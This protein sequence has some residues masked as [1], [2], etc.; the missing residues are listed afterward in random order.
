MHRGYVKIWRKSIDGGWL[1]NPKLWTFWCYCLLRA[2]H[3]PCKV[4]LGFTEIELEPGQFIFGRKQASKDIGLS[5]RTVRTC[6][7]T[8]KTTS[9]V[10]IK[11]TNRYSII[12]IINWNSYQDDEKITTSKA[13]SKETNKRPADDQQT[14]TDKHVKNVKNEKKKDREGISGGNGIPEWIPKETW[15]AFKEFRI[16]KKAPLTELAIKKTISELEKLKAEGHEPREVLEQSV[17]RGWTGVFP[18]KGN[19]EKIPGFDWSKP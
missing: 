3:R 8:L 1:S 2:N 6:L 9:N 10:T 7:H 15:E 14:T 19:N 17:Y 11:T 4:V 13:T 5:E 12:S 18:I 16:R